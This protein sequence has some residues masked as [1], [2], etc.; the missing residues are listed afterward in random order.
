MDTLGELLV[1]TGVGAA[2]LLIGHH[3]G[4]CRGWCDGYIDA[5]EDSWAEHD[6]IKA[7]ADHYGESEN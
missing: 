1:V 7:C 6:D 2:C 3:V 5:V 4:K